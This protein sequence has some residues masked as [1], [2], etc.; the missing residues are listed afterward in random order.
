MS[1]EINNAGRTYTINDN[2]MT[3]SFYFQPYDDK[4]KVNLGV[5]YLPKHL[6][7]VSVIV[8]SVN[9]LPTNTVG[10]F[11]FPI[12]NNKLVELTYTRDLIPN[13]IKSVIEVVYKLQVFA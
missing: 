8:S 9:N 11:W 5:S 13:N 7:Y 12:V 1:L 2:D 10:S 3:Y 4:R 6:H